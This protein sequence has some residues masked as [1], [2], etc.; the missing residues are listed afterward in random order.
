VIRAASLALLS[1][2]IAAPAAAD[3]FRVRTDYTISS[4]WNRAGSLD[5]T[6]GYPI[7]RNGNGSVR[8]MWDKAVGDFRF[9]AHSQMS[10]SEGDNLGYAIA[11]APFLP[12]PV[13]ATLFDLTQTWATTPNGFVTNTIDRLSVTYAAPRFV[14]KLGRQAITWGVGTVFHPG[15]IVAPFAPSATDTAYK[16][17]ADMVYSQVLFDNGADVQMIAVPRGIT[18][19]GPVAF[20]SSTYALRARA[21][22]GSLDAS[23]MLARDRGDNVVGASLSGALGGA[24]WNAEYVHYALAAGTSHP[25]WV[26]NVAN[27][28]TLLE[29]NI[30]YF[31]EYYHNGFGTVPSVDLAS[32]PVSLTDRMA[33]GQVFLP[34]VNFLALGGT[35]QLTPDLSF[36]TS[37]II[38]MAD[39]S[40]L[41]SL[42]LNYVLGDNTNLVATYFHAWGAPGTEFGG[43][44]TAPASGIFAT[45]PR[46]ASVQLVHFF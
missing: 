8:L 37:A 42:S 20:N 3:G 34:G 16:P 19:G 21:T 18:L 39:R 10:F 26:V 1:A 2:L 30:S 28:G 38:S 45:T 24:S 12:T 13:P 17:G 27:F 31:A 36:G 43:R 6:L 29:R 22:L 5:T 9:E 40:S 14:L 41:G 15:D 23:V 25:S 46:S 35:M 44:E 33:T 11:I 7:R 4:A 32:L